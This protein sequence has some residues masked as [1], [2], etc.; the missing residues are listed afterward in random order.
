MLNIHLPPQKLYVWT[1]P[2]NEATSLFKDVKKT[3]EATL[4]NL[5]IPLSSQ[6]SMES[7]RKHQFPSTHSYN[8]Q[9]CFSQ[10]PWEEKENMRLLSAGIQ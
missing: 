10:V 5:V 4:V 1:F 9:Y 7:K 8:A 3:K 2:F 6:L